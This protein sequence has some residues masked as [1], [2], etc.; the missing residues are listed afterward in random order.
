MNHR[1]HDRQSARS[2]QKSSQEAALFVTRPFVG[3]SETGRGDASQPADP[4]G[5]CFDRVPLHVRPTSIQLKPSDT[6]ESQVADDT[7]LAQQIEA[8]S[9]GGTSL[10]TGV[11][12][13]LEGQLAASLGQVRI[14]ADGEADA[15]ARSVSAKAFTT[16]QDIFFRA[17]AYNPDSPE[18]LRLLA[19]EVTHTVQ[20][21]TGPVDGNAAPGGVSI[22]DPGDRFEQAADQ[23]ANQVVAAQ[24][25]VMP[26]QR[27][28]D[29][30]D[31]PH[32]YPF[33][34][35]SPSSPFNFHLLP[36]DPLGGGVGYGMP[37]A[38]M[39]PELDLDPRSHPFGSPLPPLSLGSDTDTPSTL[40]WG[41]GLQGR[42]G[43]D[44][45][46]IAAGFGFRF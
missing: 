25:T 35:G 18:G 33:P 24:T 19:H 3:E 36:G 15:L 28:D 14:H 4:R 38:P 8:A 45:K 29:D 9:G 44:E 11:R 21:A 5:H 22:S 1:L 46:S 17:G 16:G 7:D 2:I 31:P 13:Q 37:L 20:Q 10:A 32:F 40:P 27:Q 26:I 23:I 12:N 30:D 6:A 39:L 42:W 34:Q 41:L 43:E